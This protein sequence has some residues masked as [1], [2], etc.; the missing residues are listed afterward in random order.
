MGSE[1]K[2]P[3]FGFTTLNLCFP[4]P[5]EICYLFSCYEARSKTIGLKDLYDFSPSNYTQ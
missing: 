2:S 4:K 5:S 3:S 1:K